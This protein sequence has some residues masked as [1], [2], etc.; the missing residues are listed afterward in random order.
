MLK[1]VAILFLFTVLTSFAEEN[2]NQLQEPAQKDLSFLLQEVTNDL[3]S[4]LPNLG[5]PQKHRIYRD[6]LEIKKELEFAPA[7]YPFK[8]TLTDQLLKVY[9]LEGKL[10][11]QWHNHDRME[12]RGEVMALLDSTKEFMALRSDGTVL[13]SNWK[14]VTNYYLFD[15]YIG[16]L[17][18]KGIFETFSTREKKPLIKNWADTTSVVA[19]PYYTALLDTAGNLDG[20]TT[21]GNRILQVKRVKSVKAVDYRSIEYVNNDGQTFSFQLVQ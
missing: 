8:Y 12:I 5:Q 10:L 7:N 3:K 14:D 21:D 16:L 20:Y 2:E 17:D 19:M 4:K 9:N 18:T 15:D 13:V 11:Q 6:L 1:I